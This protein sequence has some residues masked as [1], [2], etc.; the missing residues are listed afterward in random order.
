[1]RIE[2][3][4][5]STKLIASIDDAPAKVDQKQFRRVVDSVVMIRDHQLDPKKR[6]RNEGVGR[7]RVAQTYRPKTREELMDF[8]QR[9]ERDGQLA[10]KRLI[11]A[12]LRLVVS[13]A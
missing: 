13:I 6:L 1:M 3:D 9:V 5:F 4:E 11:E 7:E 12:N 2:G 10:K 8:C